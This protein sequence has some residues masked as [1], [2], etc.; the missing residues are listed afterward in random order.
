MMSV[1]GIV[2]TELV[3]ER[4]LEGL[5]LVGEG[6]RVGPEVLVGEREKLDVTLK[7]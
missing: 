2:D 7:T 1:V 6:G 5:N 4:D 3:G